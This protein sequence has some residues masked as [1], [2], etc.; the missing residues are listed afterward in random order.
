M[1]SSPATRSTAP[2]V[3]RVPNFI[4]KTSPC[5]LPTIHSSV[6]SFTNPVVSCVLLAMPVIDGFTDLHHEHLFHLLKN[7]KGSIIFFL[8]NTSLDRSIKAAVSK[9]KST[10][11][12][13]NRTILAP[14][15]RAAPRSRPTATYALVNSNT[16]LV[17]VLDASRML[18]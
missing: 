12:G 14:M 1:R 11:Y 6:R 2:S 5:G 10:C 9:V 16:A 18:V 7:R 3:T 8:V 4:F 13:S 15:N 17:N